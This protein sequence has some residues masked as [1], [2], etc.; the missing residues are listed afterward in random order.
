[1]AR[2]TAKLGTYESHT[3][4]GW[5]SFSKIGGFGSGTTVAIQCQV[6]YSKHSA[7]ESFTLFKGVTDSDYKIIEHHIDGAALLAE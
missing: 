2:L 7:Q 1:M 6:K 5:R 4:T 3:I